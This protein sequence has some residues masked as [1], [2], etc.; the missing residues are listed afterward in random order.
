MFISLHTTLS[1]LFRVQPHLPHVCFSNTQ[2]ILLFPNFACCCSLSLGSC[3]PTLHTAGPSHPANHSSKVISSQKFSCSSPVKSP[4]QDSPQLFTRIHNVDFFLHLIQYLCL[5]CL[6]A[7]LLHIRAH[8]HLRY[9]RMVT[10]MS[11]GS[12]ANFVTYYTCDLD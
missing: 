7:C 10:T 4:S 1:L 9:T 5:C 8:K 12:N 11:P 3:S 6:F 2:S